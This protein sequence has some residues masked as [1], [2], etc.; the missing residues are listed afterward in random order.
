MCRLLDELIIQITSVTLGKGIPPGEIH[1]PLRLLSLGL[2][3]RQ[4][5]CRAFCKIENM[6]GPVVESGIAHYTHRVAIMTQCVFAVKRK[7]T[8]EVKT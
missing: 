4:V 3:E 7:P 8:Y 2:L 6:T 1:P 5:I